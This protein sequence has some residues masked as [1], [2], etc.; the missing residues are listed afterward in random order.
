[1]ADANA[2]SDGDSGSRP[3]IDEYLAHMHE[4]VLGWFDD[5]DAAVF[6]AIDDVQGASGVKGD[7]LE[8]GTYLGKSAI[9]LG[10]L[11][12]PQERLVVC[13]LFTNEDLDPD[14]RRGRRV[15]RRR[16]AVLRSRRTTPVP[17]SA[18]ERDRAIFHRAH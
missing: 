17:R 13:D 14:A 11:L 12:R 1:M 6:R 8:I 9:L 18:R 10:Y 16:S 15:L 2:D 5:V 7:L 3:T 4:L